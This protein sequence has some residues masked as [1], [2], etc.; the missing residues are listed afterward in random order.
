MLKQ[1]CRGG[2][3][4]F[5][6]S[7]EQFLWSSFQIAD[8]PLKLRQ[9]VEHL[10]SLKAKTRVEK[11]KMASEHKIIFTGKNKTNRTYN[12][13]IKKPLSC[14]SSLLFIK[15]SR[16]Y[17][18]ANIFSFHKFLQLQCKVHSQCTGG[19]QEASRFHHNCL[20]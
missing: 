5:F 8:S 20:C 19:G 4:S 3:N 16:T 6:F 18:Y 10:S 9:Y 7:L 11:N 14:P 2:N 15:I 17:E 1:N 13:Q 12:F